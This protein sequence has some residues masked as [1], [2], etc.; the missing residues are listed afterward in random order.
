MSKNVGTSSLA[1]TPL[2]CSSAGS[3]LLP[4]L[5]RLCLNSF[6]LTPR[7]CL[8]GSPA[9]LCTDSG[10]SECGELLVSSAFC[11]VNFNPISWYSCKR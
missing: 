6:L 7:F 8:Q 2:L 9:L 1:Y 3:T 5:G 11:P 10:K 4:E